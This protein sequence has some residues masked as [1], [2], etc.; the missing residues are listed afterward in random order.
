MTTYKTAEL[1]GALLDAAVAKA[2]GD[3][4]IISRQWAGTIKREC[5]GKSEYTVEDCDHVYFDE[6]RCSRAYVSCINK[7]R[8]AGFW[9]HY[10]GKWEQGGPIIERERITVQASQAGDWRAFLGRGDTIHAR[11]DTPLVAAMRAYVASK[12]GDTVELP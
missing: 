12:L 5:E 1:T 11:A 9:L 10:S 3:D 4:F 7:E 6:D 8:R 2:E